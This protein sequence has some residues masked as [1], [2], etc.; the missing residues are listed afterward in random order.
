MDEWT[1]KQTNEDKHDKEINKQTKT[2]KLV[3]SKYAMVQ[4]ADTLFPLETLQA[5]L[6]YLPHNYYR[7]SQ[8]NIGICWVRHRIHDCYHILGNRLLLSKKVNQ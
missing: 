5:G 7:S 8:L 2:N 4:I 3:W 6:M 1:N